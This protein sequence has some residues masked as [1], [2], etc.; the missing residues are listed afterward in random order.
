MPAFLH[1]KLKPAVL[2]FQDSMGMSF[3]FQSCN[4]ALN[5]SV[6]NSTIH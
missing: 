2:V 6:M 4:I 3:S 5:E 1:R